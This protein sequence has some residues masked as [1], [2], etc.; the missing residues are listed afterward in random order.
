MH[1]VHH[2]REA[3]FTNTNF[4]NLVSVWDRLFGTFTP[5]RQARS[6][7]YGLEGTDAPATQTTA[8]LL[9]LPFRDLTAAT[10]AASIPAMTTG[11]SSITSTRVS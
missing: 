4:S 1:K 10:R 9:A 2:A 5:V 11:A 3:R 7:V 6:I 8:G